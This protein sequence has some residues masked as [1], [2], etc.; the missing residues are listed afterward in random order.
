MV[1]RRKRSDALSMAECV[2]D[3]LDQRDEQVMQ[4]LLAAGIFVAS[5]DGRVTQI[6]RDE[7]L[8]FVDRQGFAPTISR[9]EMSEALDS[10]MQQFQA[11]G[12]LRITAESLRPLASLS[13]SSVVVRTAGRVA[14]AD[15]ELH[16]S[17]IEAIQTLRQILI[18]LGS[19]TPPA[20][21]MRR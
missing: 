14:A 6:E 4:A 13:L 12:L 19:A 9:R 3:Y 10:L 11:D 17:E 1:K 21:R 15:R 18:K 5:A 20:D 7:L 8:D 16:P 2:A